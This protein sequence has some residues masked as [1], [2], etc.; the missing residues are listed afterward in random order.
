MS[1]KIRP[2][3]NG[4]LEVDIRIEFPDGTHLRER[5]KAQVSSKSG[6]ERWGRAR[7]AVLLS[8]GHRNR[9]RRH[10]HSQTLP[11]GF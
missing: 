7:E 9:E 1:V 2:Y 8:Q 5:R 6:A 3:I 10:P 11:L 4:G